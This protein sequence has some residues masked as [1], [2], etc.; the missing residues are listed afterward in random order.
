MCSLLV[1]VFLFSNIL[2]QD[3]GL[4]LGVWINDTSHIILDISKGNL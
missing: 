4:D 3:V 2:T 1:I